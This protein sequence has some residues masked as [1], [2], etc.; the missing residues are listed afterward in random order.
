MN[1]RQTNHAIRTL[2]LAAKSGPLPMALHDQITKSLI[3]LLRHK[4]SIQEANRGKNH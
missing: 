3:D 1:L 2:R 4:E